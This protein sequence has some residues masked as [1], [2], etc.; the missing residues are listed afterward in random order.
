[1]PESELPAHLKMCKGISTGRES[2]AIKSGVREPEW[3]E[4]TLGPGIKVLAKYD[5][6]G[7]ILKFLRPEDEERWLRWLHGEDV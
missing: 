7:I 2:E 1:M 3:G 5:E 4:I 6:E